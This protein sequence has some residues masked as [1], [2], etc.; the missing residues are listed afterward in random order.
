[1]SQAADRPSF[2]R[3]LGDLYPDVFAALE[4]LGLAVRNAGPLEDKMVH[5][6]QLGAAAV[7][8]SEGAVHSHTR[9]ALAAGATPEEIRHALLAVASTAGFPSVVAALSWAEDELVKV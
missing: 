2:Y 3:Q 7:V 6:V 4:S 1:M 9:R 8:R 5:L